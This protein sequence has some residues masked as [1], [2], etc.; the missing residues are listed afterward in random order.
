MSS[1]AAQAWG[2]PHDSMPIDSSKRHT[3]CGL[4]IDFAGFRYAGYVECFGQIA[5]KVPVVAAADFRSRASEYGIKLDHSHTF[6]MSRDPAFNL[7]ANQLG[8]HSQVNRSM[9]DN[10]VI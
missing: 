8:H 6:F 4:G 2:N 10:Q 5:P 1:I 3:R 9:V 7:P